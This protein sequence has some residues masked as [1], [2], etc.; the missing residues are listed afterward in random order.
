MSQQRASLWNRLGY[1][2]RQ[3]GPSALSPSFDF[4][5]SVMVAKGPAPQLVVSASLEYQCSRS[6][7]VASNVDR[8]VRETSWRKIT[9]TRGAEAWRCDMID[10]IRV[11]ESGAPASTFHVARTSFES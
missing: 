1:L 10:E 9:L 3:T 8:A 11:A 5:T 4:E 6:Q 2:R 7:G